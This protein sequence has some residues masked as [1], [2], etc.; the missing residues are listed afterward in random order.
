MYTQALHA[1]VRGQDVENELF[2]NGHLGFMYFIRTDISAGAGYALTQIGDIK[3][4]QISTT[5]DY[6]VSW[7]TDAYTQYI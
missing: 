4:H 7:R 1:G 5:L 3:L 6:A 2:R